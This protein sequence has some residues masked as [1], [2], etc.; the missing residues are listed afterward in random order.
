MII[1]SCPYCYKATYVVVGQSKRREQNLE[2]GSCKNIFLIKLKRG[3]G[4]SKRVHAECQ[5]LEQVES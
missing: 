1:V 3:P 2:C 5:R 4:R